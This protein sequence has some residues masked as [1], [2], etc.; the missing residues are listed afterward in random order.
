LQ[1]PQDD[2]EKIKLAVGDA[3]PDKVE[4]KEVVNLND[5]C[6][7]EERRFKARDLS[8]VVSSRLEQIFD[9][10]NKEL[11]QINKYANLPGGAIIYGGGSQTKHIID[12][13]KDC[14]KLPVRIA[15]PEFGGFINDD[16][17]FANAVGNIKFFFEDKNDNESCNESKAGGFIAKILKMFEIKL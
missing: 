6:P 9:L 5:F 3:Y 13:A 14:L 17:G 2:G 7:N 16:P 8:V 15:Q 12:L 11:K 1:I 10:I 4:T